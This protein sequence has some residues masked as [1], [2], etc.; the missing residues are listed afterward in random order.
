MG[1]RKAE[2]AAD[3]LIMLLAGKEMPS[4]QVLRMAR[5]SGICEKTL[6]RAKK[7]TG[8]K[9]RKECGKS[10]DWVMSVPASMIGRRFCAE[11]SFGTE[12]ASRLPVSGQISVDWVSVCA[13]NGGADNEKKIEIPDYHPAKAGMRIKMGGFEIE[14]D[15]HF[16]TEKLAELLRLM[17]GGAIC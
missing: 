2:E 4:A 1:S 7:M 17:G 12:P 14:T 5:E 8:A 10:K 6:D 16:P 13:M 11:R 9:S 15:E 3:F